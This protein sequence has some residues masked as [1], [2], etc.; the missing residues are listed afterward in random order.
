MRLPRLPTVFVASLTSGDPD[1]GTFVSY[2]LGAVVPL[3]ALGFMIGRYTALNAGAIGGDMGFA[4]LA[5]GHLLGLFMGISGLSLACFFL[6]RQLVRHSIEVNRQL[7]YFDN[8]TGLPNR[9]VFLD[10]AELALDHARRKKS[11]FAVC[12]LDL[13]RFKRVNDTLGH[14]AGDELLCEVANRL[15]GIVRFSDS[16][17]HVDAIDSK[18]GVARLGGDEFTLLLTDIAD[19]HGAE[20]A[21]RRVLEALRQPFTVAGRELVVTACL[22]I[23]IYPLDG[24]DVETLLKNADTA[25]SCAKELGRNNL[26]FFSASM[27]TESERKLDI[28][29]RLRNALSRNKLSVHYQPVRDVESGR[30]VAA[31]A[32]VRWEEPELGHISPV[33]F[34]P[35]AEDS[36]LINQLGE[37]VLG[38]ACAQSRA[39]QDAGFKPIRMAVN[40]S[41]LQAREPEFVEM[42]RQTLQETG[43]RAVHLELEITES[44]IMQDDDQID[45]AFQELNDLG[46]G[47]ALDDFGTGYSSLTYLRRFPISRVK[48]D[49]SFVEGIPDNTENLAVTAAIISMARNLMML[50]VGEGVE[51][52]EQAQSLRE[53]G[54]DE[55]QGYLLSPAV[56]APDFVQFLDRGKRET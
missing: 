23:A 6:L 3:V 49:R 11:L 37:W 15:V 18:L 7:A 25:M 27:N 43:L 41:G 21:A 52:E 39:W 38:T 34:I 51:T 20:R 56:P 13:D 22:G 24:N 12:F 47:L 53:L 50:V 2:F 26:K 19:P 33:E 28:E 10:R 44:T 54:C 45:F 9:R 17:A 30:V 16:V 4:P 8:L 14:A 46:V 35:I 36:G 31:E 29:E 32:L 55:I 1:R 42:V 5:P 48:V 40:V